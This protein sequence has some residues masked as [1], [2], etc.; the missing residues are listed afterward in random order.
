MRF[1]ELTIFNPTIPTCDCV[2]LDYLFERMHFFKKM[3][4][5][6]M[7]VLKIFQ[8]IE[9]FMSCFVNFIIKYIYIGYSESESEIEIESESDLIIF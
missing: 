5:L 9:I 1:S 4:N 3:K 7:D 2:S 8:V 6:L